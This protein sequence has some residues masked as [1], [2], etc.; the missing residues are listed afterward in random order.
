[1]SEHI[2]VK[3]DEVVKENEGRLDQQ[4]GK[5]DIEQLEML[6]FHFTQICKRLSQDREHWAESGKDLSRAVENLSKVLQQLSKLEDRIKEQVTSVISRES[7]HAAGVI[8]ES[9]GEGAQQVL[10]KQIKEVANHLNTVIREACSTLTDYKWQVGS[11]KK[12]F[13]IGITFSSLIGNILAGIVV[14][15]FLGNMHDRNASEIIKEIR[16]LVRVEESPNSTPK[17]KTHK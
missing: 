11:L 8:A 15:H 14:Y 3:Q 9:V 2:M 5:K 13:L 7:H 1:M 4:L 6:A 12:W 17:S 16:N 10:T